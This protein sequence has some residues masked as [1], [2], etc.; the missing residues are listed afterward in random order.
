MGAFEKADK[1]A[2]QTVKDIQTAYK[3]RKELSDKLNEKSVKASM[4]IMFKKSGE[5][6]AKTSAELKSL[7]EQLSKLDVEGPALKAWQDV[8]GQLKSSGINTRIIDAI[9]AAKKMNPTKKI[10][11]IV[12]ELEKKF[13]EL[14]DAAFVKAVLAY[15][16]IEEAAKYVK[17]IPKKTYEQWFNELQKFFNDNKFDIVAYFERTYGITKDKA[18]QMFKTLNDMSNVDFDKVMGDYVDPAKKVA[19]DVADRARRVRHDIAQPTQEL[20]DLY[21]NKLSKFTKKNTDAIYNRLVE[22]FNKL[23]AIVEKNY[24]VVS[25]DIVKVTGETMDKVEKVYANFMATYGDMTWEQISN[26]V[27][28]KIEKQVVVFKK[29]TEAE[30]QRLMVLIKKLKELAIKTA[31]K[32]N[33]DAKQVVAK[34]H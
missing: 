29:L 11:V 19:E 33:V 18:E 22:L 10:Q 27:Y 34:A 16:K 4:D 17:T 1:V 6:L 32:V 2:V 7:A 12:V 5:I 21:A 28:N 3:Q 23:K 31:A 9:E 20:K 14:Y 8:L 13:N 25:K 26:N 30:I 24:A 15:N